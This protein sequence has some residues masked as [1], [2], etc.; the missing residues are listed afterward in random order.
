MLTGEVI[1]A[2]PAEIVT[3]CRIGESIGAGIMGHGNV[4]YCP[5]RADTVQ[6]FHTLD[7]IG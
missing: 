6:F 7:D 5:V 1:E 3:V 2:K 4:Y